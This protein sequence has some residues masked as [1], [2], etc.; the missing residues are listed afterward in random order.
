M[1][2][3]ASNIIDFH[4]HLWTYD[5][6]TSISIRYMDAVEQWVRAAE[7]HDFKNFHALIYCFVFEYNF[8]LPMFVNLGL[9][10]CR[11]IYSFLER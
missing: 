10:L 9:L 2:I 11:R 6:Q 7:F 8:E 1:L 5:I 3:V 4:H